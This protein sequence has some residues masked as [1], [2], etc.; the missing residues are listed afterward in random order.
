[1]DRSGIAANTTAP[2][3]GSA[4]TPS[5]LERFGVDPALTI[6]ANI[7]DVRRRIESACR[8]VD[9]DPAGVR[10][11]PISKTVPASVVRCAVK[12]GLDGFGENKIQEAERKAGALS[13]LGLRWS[14]VGH[15][16]TN[17]VRNLARFASEFHALDSMRVAEALNT[18]L[19]AEDRELDVFVQV[20][21]S[22]EETKFGLQP[23]DVS[24]FVQRL[25]E[26]PR[27][28]VRGLMTLAIFSAETER[29]RECFRTLRGLRDALRATVPAA[30]GL[31][32]LSMGM[33]GDFETAIEEGATVVRVGQ[34]IFGPRPGSDAHYWPGLIP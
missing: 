3:S 9:R 28:K 2:E 26:L 11:L 14:I 15:L 5:D 6:G 8:R 31:A 21:T 13:D 4:L 7:A 33:S 23:E 16:Q 18:R 25:P 20:N 24:A 29:V 30:G 17:K 19:T 32:E 12:A 10:L 34:A 27:L 1:M 22:G